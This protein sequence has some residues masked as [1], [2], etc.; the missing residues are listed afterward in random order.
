MFVHLTQEINY[1]N[2]NM[3]LCD[4][5]SY[6]CLYVNAAMDRCLCMQCKQ[7]RFCEM[8]SWIRH[9]C[10]YSCQVF[11]I[12][13]HQQMQNIFIHFSPFSV[14]LALADDWI[15]FSILWKFIMWKLENY[16]Y[17]TFSKQFAALYC[18]SIQFCIVY[19]NKFDRL[20]YWKICSSLFSDRF[21]KF[22]WIFS[23]NG[24]D[25]L[26]ALLM[27]LCIEIELFAAINLQTIFCFSFVLNFGKIKM[28]KI[29]GSLAYPRCPIIRILFK[30]RWCRL[31]IFIV[32]IDV[33][34]SAFIFQC[35]AKAS[36]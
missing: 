30:L 22:F 24:I 12:F 5:V 27:K 6:L 35:T 21:Y 4:V 11:G 13:D 10:I 16:I 18:M 8:H 33:I 3:V 32:L 26:S 34:N 17:N 2:L 36:V 20:N 9:N 19:D 1:I 14:G 28:M 31:V 29:F 25:S 23:M 15:Q 7:M